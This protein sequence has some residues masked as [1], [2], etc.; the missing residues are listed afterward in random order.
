MSGS[1]RNR[2]ADTDDDV[3]IEDFRRDLIALNA[4][5]QPYSLAFDEEGCR[6]VLTFA[7]ELV[8]WND[9]LN[10]VSRPDAPHVISKHVA[11]SLGPLL[12]SEPAGTDRWIDVGTGAG[13]PGLILKIARPG[14]D[15]TLLE[16]SR[17]RC[18]FLDAVAR[19]IGLGKL[20]ILQLRAE[21][22]L[23][24]GQGQSSYS[25]VTCRAVAALSESL[26]VFGA[27]AAP[28]GRLVTF[29][30][31]QWEEDLAAARADGTLERAGFELETATRIPWYQGHVLSF[32]RR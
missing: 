32:R 21:T 2:G 19:R 6:R 31:P 29:K 8:L 25:V 5:L 9:R 28:G 20:P 30:G 10:L 4:A 26:I 22:L 12:L 13:F 1:R 18:V 15:M 14:L 16:S 11:A 7:S 23:A 17:K 24:R 3:P 27:L